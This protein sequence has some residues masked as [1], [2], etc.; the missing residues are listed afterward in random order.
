M[1]TRADVERITENLINELTIV[2]TNGPWTNPNER[3]V[4]LMFKDRVISETSFD[5][6]QKDEYEG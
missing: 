1:L 5:V 3:V 2:V 6:V 4:K